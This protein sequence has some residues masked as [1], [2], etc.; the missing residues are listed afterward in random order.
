[1]K[2]SLFVLVVLVT[3]LQACKKDDEDPTPAPTPTPTPTMDTIAPV[4]T[5][6][7]DNPYIIANIG[8]A[9]VEPGYSATDNVDGN[10]TAWVITDESELNEDSAGDYQIYYTAFDLAGNT[11][12]PQR[13]VT[14]KNTADQY[15]G[16]YAV[17]IQCPGLAD[18]NFM[19]AITTSATINNKIVFGKFGNYVDAENKVYAEINGGSITLP[20]QTYTVGT[21]ALARTFSGTGT[22]SSSGGVTTIVITVTE[23]VVGLPA[24]TCNY[25]WTK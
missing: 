13:T 2:K 22:I 5:L 25:T 10:V 17:V 1:M 21:P 15:Q 18:Y 11:S 23:S 14:V 19:E 4:I 16:T 20:T 12:T 6:L 3:L 9:Y 7:G 24:L 8:D